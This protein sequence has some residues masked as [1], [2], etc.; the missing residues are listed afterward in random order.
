MNE[1][2]LFRQIE[3]SPEEL[4]PNAATVFD[5][6]TEEEPEIPSEAAEMLVALEAPICG[7]DGCSLS[8]RGLLQYMM[9]TGGGASRQALDETVASSCVMLDIPHAAEEILGPYMYPDDPRSQ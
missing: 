4:P 1:L 8:T 9:N 3:A 5:V 2:C 7:V 6:F